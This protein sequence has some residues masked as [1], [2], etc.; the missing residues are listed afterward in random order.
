MHAACSGTRKQAAQT[1]G[2]CTYPPHANPS[3]VRSSGV[4]VPPRKSGDSVE[5]MRQGRTPTMP[6]AAAPKIAPTHTCA[7]VCVHTPTHQLTVCAHADTVDRNTDR[8][9]S[10]MRQGRPQ[11][12]TMYMIYI[13]TSRVQ[14]VGWHCSHMHL[15]HH[16]H[17]NTHTHTQRTSV[18]ARHPE[19]G[20]ALKSIAAVR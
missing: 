14:P 7:C 4:S 8:T 11:R 1:R 2:R 9:T 10:M 16:T 15:K 3:I 17:N 6:T 5:I 18:P 20:I 13:S 19:C 12:Y